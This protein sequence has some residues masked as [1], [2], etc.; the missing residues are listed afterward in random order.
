MDG[1]IADHDR[2]RQSEESPIGHTRFEAR[3]QGDYANE[4]RPEGLR[5]NKIQHRGIRL[6]GEDSAHGR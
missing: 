5:V 4:S 3:R 2:Q 1:E 6:G